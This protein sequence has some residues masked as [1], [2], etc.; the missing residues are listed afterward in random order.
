MDEVIADGTD[1][2]LVP[3]G[4]V[5]TLAAAIDALLADPERRARMGAAGRAK[6]LAGYTWDHS[7]AVVRDVYQR[8]VGRA[9]DDRP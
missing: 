5:A 4:D 2:V 7:Y 1:G 9:L 3:F 6:V 8:L